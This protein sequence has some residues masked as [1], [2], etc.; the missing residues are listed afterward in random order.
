M[1][2][3]HLS[4]TMYAGANMGHP[5]SAAT[6]GLRFIFASSHTDSKGWD[7]VEA[8]ASGRCSTPKRCRTLLP[9]LVSPYHVAVL[10]CPIKSSATRSMSANLDSS[11]RERPSLR[12]GERP[13]QGFIPGT[14]ELTRDRRI[15]NDDVKPVERSRNKA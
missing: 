10:A 1:G 15:R 4:R 2:W 14:I 9:N 5:S 6:K 7:I 12:T 11:V 8:D 13:L 3:A